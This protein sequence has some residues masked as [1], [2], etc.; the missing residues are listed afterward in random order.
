MSAWPKQIKAYLHS[1]KDY[2]GELSSTLGLK[3]EAARE[4][5][6]ALYE[7][8]FTLLVNENGTYEIIEVDKQPIKKV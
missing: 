1:N 6:Y 8:E 3:D 7:V 2:M 4:F 5:C